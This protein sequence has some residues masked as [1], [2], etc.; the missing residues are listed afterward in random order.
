MNWTRGISVFLIAPILAVG[1]Y[2]YRSHVYGGSTLCVARL[3]TGIPCPGCGLTRATCSMLHGEWTLSLSMHLLCLPVLAYLTI[4][5]L[6]MVS[7]ALGSDWRPDLRRGSFVLLVS[8]LVYHAVRLVLFFS[9]GGWT[10]MA[11]RNV[12]SRLLN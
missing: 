2:L 3:I 11:S 8:M 12:I 5:W 7:Q 4:V 9:N 1:L 6:G 10:E